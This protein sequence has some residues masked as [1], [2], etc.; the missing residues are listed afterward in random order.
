MRIGV[1]SDTHGSLSAWQAAISVFNRVDLIIHVGD[2]LYHGPRNPLPDGHAPKEL[3]AVLN[4][5]EIPLLFVRG[6]CD[7][8]VDQMVL[9]WPIQNP[10]LL[11]QANGKRIMAQ[12][13]HER[14][15]DE[16]IDLANRYRVDILLTGH[17]HLP[18][19]ED[20]NGII[21]LNPGS[22]ALPKDVDKIPTAAVLDKNVID[23]IRLDNG[24]VLSSLG[25]NTEG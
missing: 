19:L 1:I 7:C 11:V 2:V 13:G 17:T 24:D 16:Q 12:H 8:E 15:I 3:A 4:C 10:Y 23:I 18:R 25:Y 22:A 21:V 20:H 6:N 9:D 5:S 14:G